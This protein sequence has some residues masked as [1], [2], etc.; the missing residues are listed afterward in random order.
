VSSNKVALTTGGVDRVLFGADGITGPAVQ[1][2]PID[3]TA[4]RLMAVGA[5]GL[6]ADT[7]S[8]I[9]DFTAALRPGFYRYAE[10]TA[11]G[12][13]G[14]GLAFQ[15]MAIVSRAI[16]GATAIIAMRQTST[17]SSQRLFFG[18]RTGETGAITWRNTWHDGN[19]EIATNANGKY[20][21]FPNGKLICHHA[22]NAGSIL[23]SGT[24]T[25]DDP[26]QSAT[27]NWTYPAAFSAAPDV[28]LVAESQS[29][30]FNL[31]VL[32][33]NY[34]TRSATQ[35]ASVRAFAGTSINAARDVTV[36]MRAIGQAA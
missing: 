6:G 32:G 16:T 25:R 24:G 7:P 10:A 3:T 17:V 11:T 28:T 19:A 29:S 27:F 4:G 2:S 23:A 12:A 30:S 5:F 33:A 18:T 15:G 31:R 1:S 14:T 36:M 21:K 8:E 9:T 26:Y 34:F 13:P 35:L 20:I 22:V